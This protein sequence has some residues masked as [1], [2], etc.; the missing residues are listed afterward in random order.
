[1]YNKLEM[2]FI[3]ALLIVGFVHPASIRA[4]VYLPKYIEEGLANNLVMKQKNI[5][6][7]QSLLALKEARSW[8]YPSAGFTGDYTWAEGG[9]T[10]EFP[11]GDLLN[12]VYS[13][14]NQLTS[15]HNFP[16]VENSDI[17]LLPKNFYDARVRIAYPLVNT[18]LYYNY[19][20]KKQEI[21]LVEYEVETYRQELIHDI[22]TAYY[23]YCL[24]V[25]AAKVYE[26]AQD[27][28][29]RNLQINESLVRN[30]KGLAANILRA[31]SEIEAITSRL[32]EVENQQQNARSWFNFLLNRPL[33]DTV[34]YESLPLPPELS[35][36]IS[37]TP[38][39]MNRS[40]LK[41]LVTATSIRQ[42]ELSMN[43]RYAVPKVNTFVDL[44]SQAFDWQFDSK[45][46]YILAGFQVTIPI[47]SGLRNSVKIST[48]KLEMDDLAIRTENTSKQFTVAAGVARNNLSTAMVNL[49]SS[50]KQYKSARAYFNLIDKGYAEGIN[51]LIEFMD[52]RNQL[53]ASE[54]QVK[55][56]RYKVL[57]AYADLKRQTASSTI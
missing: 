46:K 5:G 55:L 8:F 54:I 25:D 26:S 22:E 47:F 32:H 31:E 35:K 33:A 6:L 17:H 11:V 40:E 1:M 43:Q 16:Q 12:P 38:V 56:N 57:S 34:I 30:G 23:N 4:Q 50:E 39:I 49:E 44:G 13:T 53:T 3:S 36:A 45:S 42:A 15:S 2:L 20:I 28:V 37:E 14:L 10:I 51:S 48:T 41:E 18:D 9:R 7:E 29:R 21:H 19:R 52:A 27:L 24:A